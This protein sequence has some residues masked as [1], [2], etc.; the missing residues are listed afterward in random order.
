MNLKTKIIYLSVI[1][2]LTLCLSSFFK[3]IPC[4]SWYGSNTGIE[5]LAPHN[6]FCKIYPGI[7]GYG[8]HNE[9]F[10][11]TN[12][13]FVAIIVIFSTLS[14]VV[15]VGYKIIRKIKPKMTI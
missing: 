2:V 6:T 11:L 9:Y 10:Y 12:T 4:K 8:P 1:L 7:L 13:P 14:I 3:I 15:F 5:D